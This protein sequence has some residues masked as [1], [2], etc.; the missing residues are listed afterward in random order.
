LI[1]VTEEVA[2]YRTFPLLCFACFSLLGAS[3]TMRPSDSLTVVLD[4]KDHHYSPRSLAAMESETQRIF[5]E[6]G[7]KL[8][9][10]LKDQLA[11]HAEFTNVVVFTL[12]GSCRMNLTPLLIDERGPLALTYTSDGEVLPFGEVR[13][14]RVKA[15]LQRS[16]HP[17][18]GQSWDALFGVALGRV[19]AHE[20][21]HMLSDERDH[22]QSGV[23]RASLRADELVSGT[24]HLGPSA[25]SRIDSRLHSPKPK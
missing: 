5:D 2:M 7:M 14:D 17:S 1:G 24:L 11:E 8:D 6:T 3:A 4:I 21:Y 19:M 25:L 13:C 23:T 12:T 16:P 15:S 20:L 18:N 22:T 9:W 10:R